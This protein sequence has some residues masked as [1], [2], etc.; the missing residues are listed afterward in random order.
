M[1]HPGD[2]H[3][4]EALIGEGGNL[5]RQGLRHGETTALRP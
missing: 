4:A 3:P 1:V 2:R 5:R